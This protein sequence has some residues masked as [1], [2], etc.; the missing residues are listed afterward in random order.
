MPRLNRYIQKVF[1]STASGT[2]ISQFGSLANGTPNYTT[3]PTTIQGLSQYLSGWFNAVIG[4]NSPA[5]ED[6]NA[7]FY[8]VTYQL[9]YLM[10]LGTP[11]YDATTT[12]YIG[13][14]V[15]DGTGITYVSLTDNN[16]GNALSSATNWK[17]AGSGISG[18]ASIT[19]NT[20]LT[21]S[22][23]NQVMEVNT[24]S[25]AIT[26]TMPASPS[27]YSVF[28]FKDVGGALSTNALTINPNG[29]NIEGLSANYVVYAPYWNRGVFYDGTQYY[30]L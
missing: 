1:G 9:S 29:K 10:Q 8:L 27:A 16:T 11:E 17:R 22:N 30:L 3:N 5:I 28:Y 21:T 13:S 12:Y 4:G 20:T 2:Q 23:A 26:V 6:M 24:T 19:A 25:G 15:Q 18:S 7:L 14:I